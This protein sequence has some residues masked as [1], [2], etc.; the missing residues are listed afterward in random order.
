M[1]TTSVTSATGVL[2]AVRVR[3][4]VMT[5][6]RGGRPSARRARA[7]PLPCRISTL[8]EPGRNTNTGGVIAN[9]PADQATTAVNHVLHGPSYPSQLILPVISR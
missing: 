5:S 6:E 1:G 9:E 7:D 2:S 3:I 4:R 8:I